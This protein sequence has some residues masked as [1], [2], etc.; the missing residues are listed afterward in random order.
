MC[1]YSLGRGIERQLETDPGVGHVV[2]LLLD[3]TDLEGVLAIQVLYA[4]GKSTSAQE[5]RLY[6]VN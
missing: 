1:L 5:A 2:Q 6:T 3:Y 4:E